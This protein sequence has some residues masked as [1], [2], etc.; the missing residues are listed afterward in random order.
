MMSV[1][2]TWTTFCS[3]M[4]ISIMRE[5][6]ALW[7]L[8]YRARAFYGVRHVIDPTVLVAAAQAV[9]GAARFREQHGDVRGI[10]AERVAAVADGERV[11]VGG[12]S[13]E[14]IHTPGHAMHH[15]C[16]VD[17]DS[18]VVFTGDTFGV[19]YREFDTAAGEFIFP[20]TTPSQFDPEQLHA[21]INRI[22]E[23][24]PKTA[25]L[26]HY[27]PVR[28]VQKLGLDLHTDIDEFVRIAT[29]VADQPRRIERMAA[30][31][32]DYL[33]ARLDDHGY[34]GRAQERH[35]LLDGDIE[36]NAAGL[37]AWLS[38]RSA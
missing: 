1:L 33:S 31:I 37:D 10:P 32:F 27:G 15:L 13:F 21:S 36:L 22:L 4:C 34:S 20:T 8:R 6:R 5:A 25:Y 2:T 9:Y 11:K 24:K 16:I 26:T 28:E 14:F 29:G 23:F 3:P 30:A 38:R 18:N 7:R 12:R 35:A 19:S 17:R